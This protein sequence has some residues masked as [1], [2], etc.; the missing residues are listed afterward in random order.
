MRMSF[1]IYDLWIVLCGLALL[2]GT[3]G[4][5]LAQEQFDR[6]GEKGHLAI[7]YPMK[8]TVLSSEISGTVRTMTCDMGQEFKKGDVLITLYPGYPAAERDKARATCR[9][10]EEAFKS[11]EKLYRQKSVSTLEYT[12]A[13]ADFVVSKADLAIAEKRLAACTIRA[14]YSGKV[15]KRLVRE[16]EFVPEGQPMME[17]LDDTRVRVKFHLPAPLY[18]SVRVG[19]KYQVTARDV[20]QVFECT[21]THISPV[22]ESNT[23][24]FQV[25]AEID[26][27][28]NLIRAGMTGSVRLESR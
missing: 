13:E 10:A 26:N 12:K 1:K 27:S 21:V 20:S 22:I 23:N 15:V 9:Y 14:P 3:S 7:F 2:A 17:I 25:F 4:G 5:A 6:D 16:N 24:S 11:K 18:P 28:K 19:R 8:N